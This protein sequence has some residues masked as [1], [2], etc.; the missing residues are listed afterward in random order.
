MKY[1]ESFA[2]PHLYFWQPFILKGVW[3]SSLLKKGAKLHSFDNSILPTVFESFG[4]IY[5]NAHLATAALPFSVT[6]HMDANI[7]ASWSMSPDRKLS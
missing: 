4:T 2:S 7:I 5:S 6:P 1:T 3:G